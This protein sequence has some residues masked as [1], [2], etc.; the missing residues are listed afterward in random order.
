VKVE[1]RVSVDTMPSRKHGTSSA[2]RARCANGVTC[3]ALLLHDSG[4]TVP[5]FSCL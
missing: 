2:H 1:V 5:V 4:H 3:L